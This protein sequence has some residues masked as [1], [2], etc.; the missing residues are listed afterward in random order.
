MAVSIQN[1]ENLEVVTV[2]SLA[3]TTANH[4]SAATSLV[5]YEGDVMLV[6][7]AT[8]G[9][10]TDTPTLTVRIKQNDTSAGSYDFITGAEFT[11]VTD[12]AS[13]QKL[14]LNSNAIKRFIK[15][16]AQV[17]GTNPSFS[18]SVNLVACKKYG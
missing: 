17:S 13:V 18:Y 8:A 2:R 7:N 6:L 12:T 10:G 14:V 16:N 11:P 5:D 3:G 1:L 15:I 4:T 9:T